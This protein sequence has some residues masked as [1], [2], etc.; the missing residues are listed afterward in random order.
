MNK[1]SQIISHL[2]SSI[3]VKKK[4]LN[5]H[6]L[7]LKI[8]KLY[9]SC[10]KV[11]SKGGKIIFA[12]NGGSFGDAQHLST[13]FVSKF[14]LDRSPLNSIALGTNSSTLSAV[15]ND[16]GYDQVFSRELIALANKN[17]IFIGISTSGN[18]INIINAILTANKLNI[19]NFCLTGLDGGELSKISDC[20]MVPSNDTAHIQ[21]CHITIG[22]IICDLIE[23][24]LFK[25]K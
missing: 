11:L 17:D 22:H 12:G 23:K 18:S 8:E 19:E 6:N 20:I 4:I 15:A 7:I 2:E 21:E 14:R 3:E 25:I 1:S 13:E 10:L 5:N 24:E 9:S 16:Y